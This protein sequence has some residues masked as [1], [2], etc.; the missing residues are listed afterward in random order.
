M[1]EKLFTQNETSTD[2]LDCPNCGGTTF[3]NPKLQKVQCEYCKSVIEIES[4]EIVKEL[5]LDNLFLKA[6]PWT[7]V[8]VLKCNNCGAKEISS[9]RSIATQCSFCG[10]TNIVKTN[11]IVGMKPDGVCPFEKNIE[12]A[13][14]CAGKWIKSRFFA[15]RSFKKNAVAKGLHGVYSPVFSFDCQTKSSY[16]GLLGETVTYH[17]RSGGKTVTRSKVVT[18]PIKGNYDK[19]FDDMLVQASE[20][21]SQKTLEQL[22]PF[23]TAKSVK[24][25]QKFLTGFTANT[26]QKSGHEYWQD[27]K[28]LIY[29]DIKKNVLRKYKHDFVYT[30]NQQTDYFNASYKYLL[31][32]IYIGHHT[33]KNKVYNFFVNGC[34]GKV[35]GKTP[36][37]FWKVLLVV[38]AVL[39]A[40]AGVFALVYF[41]EMYSV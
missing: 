13:K 27:C 29:Q 26:Y 20:N 3:F 37:S 41:G 4:K 24:Y 8:Q 18:F 2:S 39:L 9:N 10:T 38:L 28:Q 31:V 5:S 34:T 14:L 22:T 7:Q 36:V 30:Y 16:S 15:P 35:T 19:N 21:I 33:H 32:P 6:K 1:T 11:E 25:N 12:D 40:I 17:V 23:P